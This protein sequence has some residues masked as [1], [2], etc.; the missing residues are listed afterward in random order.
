[1]TAPV[2]L[3]YAATTPV[4]PRVAEVMS[5]HL[6]LEGTYA[7]PASRSH[8][9]G[10]LAEQAVENA[11]RQVADLI[12]ADPREIV[13]TSGA[14]EADNLAITGYLRANRDKGRHLVTSIIEHKAVIDTAKAAEREGFDVTWLTPTPDGR[15]TPE[16]L[17]DAMRPDTV[18]V[19]LMAVNN[20]L[21]SIND[22]AALAEVAHAHGAMLHVDA[23]QAVGRIDLD[24][25]ASAVDM[26]SLSAHKAYGPKGIG[27]LFV[28]RSPDLKVE[29]LI[30]GGGHERGM[31]S[32]TL[33]THQIAGMGE[34]FALAAA[35]GDSD[36]ARITTLRDR[37]L[38]GIDDLDG[39]HLNTQLETAVPNILN[40][41][42]DG[43]DGE[44]LLMALRDIALST[45]SACNS[46]SVEPS[47][48]LKGIGVPRR[49]ALSSLRLSI[50]RFTSN[51]DI[52]RAG[53]ALRTALIALRQRAMT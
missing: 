36:Q 27:A 6:T 10:W 46:A 39:V 32:G 53:Q 25:T 3:D 30:H 41:G 42:F 15:I 24:V 14:T 5:R 29:A 2:Y 47:Y 48:V 4:D 9:P 7:N 23:A 11:R 50:G 28:R 17:A 19:S 34:A 16:Q 45:G 38:A 1:M 22:V 13:W 43:V 49:L 31:R 44:S 12:K 51:D 35:Q 21:G 33:A 26:M 52:D 18:L 8:M 37:L 40:L 20:E